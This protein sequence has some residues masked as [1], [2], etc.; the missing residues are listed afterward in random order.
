MNVF[1]FFLL[2]VTRCLGQWLDYWSNPQWS[3][4]IYNGSRY[5][6]TWSTDLLQL[7]PEYCSDCDITNL[8]LCLQ[9]LNEKGTQFPVAGTSSRFH[10]RFLA[11]NVTASLNISELT[12]YTWDVELSAKRDVDTASMQ[13][14]TGCST[15]SPITVIAT[16]G[17]SR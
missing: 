14:G 6:V 5:D 1:I 8:D 15:S 12:K 17:T 7:F 10:D 11:N 9:L 2:F 16:K 4:I 13:H 3:E